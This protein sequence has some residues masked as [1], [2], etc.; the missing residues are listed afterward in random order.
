MR[1]RAWDVI[2]TAD[3]KA[4]TVR[5]ASDTRVVAFDAKNR[6][7]EFDPERL[8]RTGAERG[9]QLWRELEA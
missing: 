1:P 6:R 4:W 7:R 8:E 2:R 3:G 5:T 9:S